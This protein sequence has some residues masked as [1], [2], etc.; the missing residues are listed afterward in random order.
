MYII[1]ITIIYA[2]IH[3]IKCKY[4]YVI[5]ILYICIYIYIYYVGGTTPKYMSERITH[6]FQT[7]KLKLS[8]TDIVI[9]DYSMNDAMYTNG[10]LDASYKIELGMERLIRN[11]IML[12]T[13]TMIE[14]VIIIIIIIIIC[15]LLL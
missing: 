10:H 11:I 5:Y 14:G 9:V 12:S 8:P 1:Y 13:K 3:Y 2:S 7:M 6:I 4:V 15:V